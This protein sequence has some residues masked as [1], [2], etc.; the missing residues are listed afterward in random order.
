MLINYNRG[1]S[2]QLGLTE[3]YRAATRFGTPGLGHSII[4]MSFVN[5]NKI[6]K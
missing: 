4:L 3:G 1:V 6:S 2:D 5:C